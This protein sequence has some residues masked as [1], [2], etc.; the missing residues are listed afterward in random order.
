MQN[1]AGNVQ[2]TFRNVQITFR[3]VAEKYKNNVAD[4]VAETNVA[5]NVAGSRKKSSVN[6]AET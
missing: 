5:D 3:S 2:I 1:V 4:N 6:V